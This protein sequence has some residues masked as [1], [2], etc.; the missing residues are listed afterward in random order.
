MKRVFSII[1]N[2]IQII[3]VIYVVL[4]ILFMLTSNKYGYSQIGNYVLDVDD[5]E[6]LIIKKTNNLKNGDLVYYYSIVK[7]KYKI[8]YSNINSI[9]DD[10]TYTLVNNEKIDSYKIIGKTYRK[11][12][13]IGYI[14][15][16]M[17]EKINFLLFCLLP[18]LIVFIYNIY[19]FIIVINKEKKKE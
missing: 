9:N 13:I 7:E 17:K 1:W 2:I 10:K 18:L 12:P 4:V 19:K 8:T 16:S 14:L 11:I 5:N 15:N 3:I 6:F